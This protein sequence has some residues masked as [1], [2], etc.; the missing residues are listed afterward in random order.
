MVMS[1]D[2]KIRP[3]PS[4]NPGCVSTNAKSSSFAFPWVVAETSKENAVQVLR[5]KL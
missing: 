1:D 3:C 2:R 5:K 4:T